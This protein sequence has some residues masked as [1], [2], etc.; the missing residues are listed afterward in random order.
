MMLHVAFTC[1]VHEPLHDDWHLAVHVADGGVPVHFALQL[2]LQFALH[3]AV[4]LVLVA[5]EAH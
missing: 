1:A 3:S 4:Q 5:S 2:P